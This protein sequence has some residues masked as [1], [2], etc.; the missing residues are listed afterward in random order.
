VGISVVVGDPISLDELRGKGAAA[1]Q[2]GPVPG[3]PPTLPSF[4]PV[5]VIPEGC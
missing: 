4:V 1:G 5:P 2:G 3:G